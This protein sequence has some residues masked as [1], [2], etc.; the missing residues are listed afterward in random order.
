M[1]SHM[2]RIH[3]EKSKLKQKPMADVTVKKKN[4]AEVKKNECNYCQIIF[5]NTDKFNSHI[6]SNHGL[7][8]LQESL[9]KLRK[10]GGKE[11]EVKKEQNFA[12][13]QCK[14]SYKVDEELK[15]HIDTVHKNE[16]IK[17]N[18]TFDDKAEVEEFLDSE[19]ERLQEHIN[20]LKG[21]VKELEMDIIVE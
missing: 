11:D 6:K 17:K 4:V 14:E 5:E 21:K 9:D 7:E 13:N 15:R 10:G 12:C 2:M 20:E 16:N 19:K 3:N 8:D 1:A 18:V